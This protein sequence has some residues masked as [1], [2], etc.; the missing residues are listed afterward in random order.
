MNMRLFSIP[1]NRALA[2]LEILLGK[3]EDWESLA[4]RRINTVATEMELVKGLIVR[5]R[6]IEMK[7]WRGILRSRRI[8]LEEREAVNFLKFAVIIE[9]TTEPDALF[10]LVDLFMRE[11]NLGSFNFKI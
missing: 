7:S 2:G 4:S 3:L 8:E 10:K 1:L 6:K 11:A 5:Y 9:H